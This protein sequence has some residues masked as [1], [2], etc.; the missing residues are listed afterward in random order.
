MRLKLF[1][2]PHHSYRQCRDKEHSTIIYESGEGGAPLLRLGWN[3]QD[4]RYMATI[5]MDSSKARRLL[6]LP[7]ADCSVVQVSQ[8][9][10]QVVIGPVA[11]CADHKSGVDTKTPVA[12]IQPNCKSVLKAAQNEHSPYLPCRIPQVVVLDIRFPTLPVAELQRHQACVNGLAWAPHSSCHICTAG[13]SHG[14]FRDIA[15]ACIPVYRLQQMDAVA[16]AC[17]VVQVRHCLL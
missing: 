1:L 8:C 16:G 7:L 2:P 3:K 4:P 17:I 10:T 5:L 14:R 6:L 15:L 11:A 12:G 13:I 9:E